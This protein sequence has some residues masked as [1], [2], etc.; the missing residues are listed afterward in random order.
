LIAAGRQAGPD[1]LFL[2]C[3]F[4]DR[5]CVG[6]LDA[7]DLEEILYMVSPAVSSECNPLGSSP[8]PLTVPRNS[9]RVK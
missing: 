8:P 3:R 7:D 6:Y 1:S 4:F 9:T 2:A 5:N